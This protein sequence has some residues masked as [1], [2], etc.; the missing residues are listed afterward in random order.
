MTIRR[1]KYIFYTRESKLVDLEKKK[2]KTKKASLGPG[3]GGG[4][5]TTPQIHPWTRL[6]R[7]RALHITISTKGVN[8]VRFSTFE[9]KKHN[10]LL[11]TQNKSRDTRPSYPVRRRVVRVCVVFGGRPDILTNR[12]GKTT[13]SITFVGAKQ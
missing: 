8:E 9:K 12:G 3:G 5:E 11:L 7:L 6:M 10:D 13:K 1:F 2:K 4:E